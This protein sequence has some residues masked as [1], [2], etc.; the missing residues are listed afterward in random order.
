MSHLAKNSRPLDGVNGALGHTRS[1]ASPSDWGRWPRGVGHST[2]CKCNLATPRRSI[3][4]VEFIK[5]RV[6]K[7]TGPA[8]STASEIALTG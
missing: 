3:N 5:S 7:P 2:E 6:K 8:Q 4:Q 1:I